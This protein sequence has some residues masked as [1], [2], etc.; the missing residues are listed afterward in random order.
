MNPNLVIATYIPSQ[1]YSISPS[2][3]SVD[4]GGNVTFTVITTGI[5]NGTVLYWTNDGTSSAAD[6]S[7]NINSGSF[8]VI[9]G[10]AA[11]TATISKTIV[12]DTTTE[13]SET[14]IINLRTESASG[15]IVATSTV[16]I[17]DTS[18][19][20]TSYSVS[21]AAGS[22]NEGSSLTFNVTGSGITDGTYYWTITNSGDFGTSSGSFTITS[23]VGAFSV[24]PT[25]DSTTEG[26]ETFT[27]SIRSGSTSGTVLAT[28][29]SVTIND[30]SLTAA[31]AVNF[32]G[33]NQYLLVSSTAVSNFGTGN[34]TVEAWVYPRQAVSRTFIT[35][36]SDAAGTSN[37]YFNVSYFSDAAFPGNVFFG[38][39]IRDAS[40]QAYMT[41]NERHA[42]NNWYH[43]AVTRTSSACRLFVNGYLVYVQSVA[44][45]VAYTGSTESITITKSVTARATVIGAFLLSGGFT[46]YANCRLSGVRIIKGVALYYTGNPPTPPVPFTTGTTIIACQSSANNVDSSGNGYVISSYNGSTVTSYP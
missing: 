25:A 37:L 14:M 13:G 46:S 20:P 40:S 35:N 24:T 42:I 2:T 38:M 28:S 19:T 4:E 29:G 5:T 16:T 43:V 7:D 26:A 34:F 27:A 33:T 31:Y 30:T 18:V 9:D 8:T 15:T 39:Q 36:S 32:N 11:I 44:A 23:N 45:N 17:N 41:G 10:L 1:S 6:F 21:P 12:A 22:V 3:A